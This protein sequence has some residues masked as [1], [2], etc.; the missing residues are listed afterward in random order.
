MAPGSRP[1]PVEARRAAEEQDP[2]RRQREHRND[3]TREGGRSHPEVTQEREE[4][5]YEDQQPQREEKVEVLGRPQVGERHRVPSIS[6]SREKGTGIAT[7]G[8]STKVAAPPVQ[9]LIRKD[10]PTPIAPKVFALFMFSVSTVFLVLGC[11]LISR[12]W[13]TD[14][15]PFSALITGTGLIFSFGFGV[16]GLRVARTWVE[17]IRDGF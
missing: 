1:S 8:R 11:L 5:R 10:S 2:Y 17:P 4:R 16:W 14:D 9:T 3:W 12:T 6:K 15:L 7:C 13:G